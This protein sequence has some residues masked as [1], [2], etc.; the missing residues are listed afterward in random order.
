M[1]GAAPVTFVDNPGSGAGP[2]MMEGS[3]VTRKSR[4]A[5]GREPEVL[6]T[7]DKPGK[8]LMNL[9]RKGGVAGRFVEEASHWDYFPVLQKQIQTP[10]QRKEHNM[11]HFHT[12]EEI[13]EEEI[14]H[15]DESRIHDKSTHQIINI[16]KLQQT[17]NFHCI[18]KCYFEQRLDDFIQY[19]S[20]RDNQMSP[21]NLLQLKEEWKQKCELEAQ[22]KI[23]IKVENM[24]LS[25]CL[26]LHCP[27]C[28]STTAMQ[29]TLSRY[30]GLSYSGIPTKRE[31]CC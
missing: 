10:Q 4:R 17:I 6:V 15:E 3:P 16:D 1:S 26:S 24:G 2:T 18:S 22:E 28:E 8:E 21:M 13:E 11:N 29:S 5:Q 31:N 30:A 19:C 14:A 9:V 7:P 23:I 12:L 25:P 27:N 20:E